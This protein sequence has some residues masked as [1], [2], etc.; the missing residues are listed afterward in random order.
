MSTAKANTGKANTSDADGATGEDA[1]A[2]TEA[3]EATGA[4]VA[5]P[6]EAGEAGEAGEGGEGAEIEAAEIE[7]ADTEAAD[8]PDLDPKNWTTAPGGR[9]RLRLGIGVG[10]I[11]ALLAVIGVEGWFVYQRHVV[12]TA[13]AEALD[14]AKEFTVTL[15]NVDPER[16]DQTFTDVLDGSTGTFHDLYSQSSEQLREA[17][18]A[19]EAAA[20]GTVIDAAVKSASKDRVEVMLF[21][22]QSVRNNKLPQVQLDRSRIVLTMEKVDGRWLASDV[23]HP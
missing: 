20:H 17:L 11:V 3:T 19:N 16:I 6:V 2:A 10:V 14:A 1:A 8:Y 9:S 12:D 22:D 18:I 23:E 21:V 15:A 13:A 7:A 4:E 5:E